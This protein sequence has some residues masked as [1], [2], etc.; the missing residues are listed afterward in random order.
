MSKKVVKPKKVAKKAVSSKVV[1]KKAPANKKKS[2]AKKDVKEKP[3]GRVI[4]YFDKAGVAVIKLTA[5]LSVEEKIR[6]KGGETDFTQK[7]KSMEIDK[8]KLKK[9]KTKQEI[10]LKVSKKTKEGHKVFKFLSI[11]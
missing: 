1:K 7:V 9:A 5:P 4:H 3:V 6:I 2:T 8:K 11:K 10:G